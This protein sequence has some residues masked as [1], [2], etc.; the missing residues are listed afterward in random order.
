MGDDS[1]STGS[2]KLP[3]ATTLVGQTDVAALEAELPVF[4]P[5]PRLAGGCPRRPLVRLDGAGLRT[6]SLDDQ[7]VIAFFLRQMFEPG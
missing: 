4:E 6:V 2:E 3:G 1:E 5:G 7:V